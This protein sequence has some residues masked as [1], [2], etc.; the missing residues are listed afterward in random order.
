MLPSPILI[1]A[2]MTAPLT[3]CGAVQQLQP[4][5]YT[6]VLRSA[7]LPEQDRQDILAS[8]EVSACNALVVS[9]I[10]ARKVRGLGYLQATVQEQEQ[11]IDHHIQLTEN[12]TAGIRYRLR[13]IKVVRATVFPPDQLRKEVHLNPGDVAS[14]SE[15]VNSLERIRVLY[16]NKGYV[17]TVIT[18]TVCFDS[19]QGLVD[20]TLE[21]DEGK[22]YRFGE[23]LLNGVEPYPGAAKQLTASWK[24]LRGQTF[25]L[26]LL[27]KWLRANQTGCPSCTAERN[28]K[29]AG[30]G[31]LSSSNLLDV[32]L[33]LPPRPFP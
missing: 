11:E 16:G 2:M 1:F 18:P 23:L 9:E 19:R 27:D 17:D 24:P 4:Q 7:D 20:V 26:S 12:I 6:L 32:T 31:I 28:I 22:P 21:M 29:V 5:T 3:N 13:A 10:V 33:H 14:G 30:H 8:T 25:N 15:I